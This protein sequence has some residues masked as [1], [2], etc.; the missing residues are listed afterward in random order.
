LPAN[1]VWHVQGDP[2]FAFA[3]ATQAG[4]HPWLAAPPD[5][6]A[7]CPRYVALPGGRAG[8][9]DFKLHRCPPWRTR[10]AWAGW[11]FVKYRHLRQLAG[12]PGLN[13]AGFRARIALDPIVTLP[14]Q[15]LALFDLKDRGDSHE[16]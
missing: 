16:A 9:L 7:G 1:V 5:A 12:Q 10:L 6:L 14:G 11:E 15:Q 13:L 3:V 8:L 4:L 2:A